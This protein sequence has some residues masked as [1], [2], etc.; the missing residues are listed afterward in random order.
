MLRCS[1]CVSVTF[2][3]LFL[4]V[5][6]FFV[7]ILKLLWLKT[8]MDLM[9]C[10]RHRTQGCPFS[11]FAARRCFRAEVLTG[12]MEGVS[13]DDGD[14]LSRYISEEVPRV[15]TLSV[16]IR[17]RSFSTTNDS[18]DLHGGVSLRDYFV[19][20]RRRL[21]ALVE[22]EYGIHDA[23]L[24]PPLLS[25]LTDSFDVAQ[26]Q[27]STYQWLSQHRSADD[28]LARFAVDRRLHAPPNLASVNRALRLL[29]GDGDTNAV[30][31]VVESTLL[32]TTAGVP[33][34]TVLEVMKA[35]PSQP[36]RASR[37][38]FQLKDALQ[39]QSIPPTV[40]SN[41]AAALAQSA[42]QLPKPLEKHFIRL[43]EHVLLMVRSTT[44]GVSES[45]VV[46]F[47]R[48]LLSSNAS[49]TAVVQLVQDELLSGRSRTVAASS[50]IQL[51]AFLG[52]LLSS[53]CTPPQTAWRC[54]DASPAG[55]AGA[56]V[57][58]ASVD[59]L[60]F[61][62]DVTKYAYALR[63]KL[64]PS[65]FD[66]VLA[67]CDKKQL[68]HRL[69]ILFI[70][71]CMLSIPTLVSLLRTMEVLHQIPELLRWLRKVMHRSATAFFLWCLRSF[72]ALTQPPCGE[73]Y[74]AAT[75]RVWSLLGCIA[76]A[77]ESEK[78]VD[79]NSA[80]EISNVLLF[81]TEEAEADH[82]LCIVSGIVSQLRMADEK[83]KDSTTK[84]LQQFH[85]PILQ[86]LLCISDADAAVARSRSIGTEL[87]ASTSLNGV[88]RHLLTSPATYC[89]VLSIAALKL[90]AT[91][92][93]SERAF[94]QMMDSY[95]QKSGALA[96][97]PYE[98]LCSSSTALSTE[99]VTMLRV[100]YREYSWFA[101][102]PLSTSLQLHGKDVT[103][104]CCGLLKAI[105]DSGHKKSIF[106][107][108]GD[109]ELS[110]ASHLEVRPAIL[111]DT[112]VKKLS[113]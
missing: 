103:E 80:S 113:V 104:I 18:T 68:Y 74:S 4:F 13:W 45:L 34:S 17:Y 37:L 112:L 19:H 1:C 30:L 44:G 73:K 89:T 96:L 39:R 75:Q 20:R 25:V 98:C 82:V 99:V 24:S 40:W 107:C 60:T 93:S 109:Q 11:V 76:A 62:S 91:N 67:L 97:L 28:I 102:L 90:L 61:A 100:W 54:R 81:C 71:M 55:T 92:T 58:L 46:A 106:L 21:D 41:L 16:N 43:F 79:D 49:T 65:A 84:V 105:Q 50:S 87:P 51:G 2:S 5:V 59:T 88:V 56:S 101:F 69:S 6:L 48:S 83:L 72:P 12:R 38:M 9:Q 110:V 108:G 70:A 77:E 111:M 57:V 8:K 15:A 27:Q 23:A 53:L 78:V 14:D 86:L 42:Q 22:A 26:R 33:L 63:L 31:D 29:G 3:P 32:N 52:D 94:T 85:V 66:A 95:Q 10:R 35:L 64:A 36:I 7:H 47:G